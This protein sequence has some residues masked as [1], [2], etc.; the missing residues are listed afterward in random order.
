MPV[1][2]ITNPLKPNFGVYLRYYR[3]VWTRSDI[4]NLEDNNRVVISEP[5]ESDVH[6]IF[7][8]A[9]VVKASTLNAY[10][11][12][13]ATARLQVESVGTTIAYGAAPSSIIATASE[14]RTVIVPHMD[15][16]STGNSGDPLAAPGR[17][18]QLQWSTSVSQSGGS[19][20]ANAL[21]VHCWYYLIPVRS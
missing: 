3:T 12:T 5:V 9:Y 18:L 20:T 14:T 2:P 21:V 6:T 7:L 15:T 8:R 4:L 19:I 16:A 10:L 17:R 13:P 1:L 11:I